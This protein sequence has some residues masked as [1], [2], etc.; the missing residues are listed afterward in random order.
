MQTNRYDRYL[1]QRAFRLCGGPGLSEAG[2]L[3]LPQ[4][5]KYRG[6]AVKAIEVSYRN[7]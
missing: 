2:G 6:D 7:A 3:S 1:Q 4:R 5:A